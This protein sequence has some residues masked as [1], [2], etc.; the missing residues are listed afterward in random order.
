MATNENV[1]GVRAD[2]IMQ[3]FDRHV[4]GY[5]TR[6]AEANKRTEDFY[7]ESEKQAKQHSAQVGQSLLDAQRSFVEFAAKVTAIVGLVAGAYKVLKDAANFR[8]MIIAGNNL[9]TS[10]GI[11]FQQLLDDFEEVTRGALTMDEKVSLANKALAAGGATFVSQIGPLY[12]IARAAAV[13]TGRDTA[14]VFQVIIQG[15]AKAQP[16]MITQADIYLKLK[17]VVEDYAKANG[18]TADSID[19][20]TQRQLV[21][22]AVLE[23]GSDLV[24]RVGD[25]AIAAKA[26]FKQFEVSIT[27]T[28]DALGLA[29]GEILKVGGVLQTFADGFEALDQIIAVAAGGVVGGITLVTTFWSKLQ[30][31]KKDIIGLPQVTPKELGDFI[32]E[33]QRAAN[34]AFGKRSSACLRWSG[35]M[36]LT[37]RQAQW[38]PLLQ[39]RASVRRQSKRSLP[40][41]SRVTIPRLKTCKSRQASPSLTPKKISMISRPKRGQIT[42]RKRMTSSPRELAARAKIQRDYNDKIASAEHDYQRGIEDANYSHGQKLASIE[43]DY[44]D[45]I[46]GIQQTYQEDALDAVRNLDAIGLLRAKERR[47]KDLANAAQNRDRAMS[48]EQENYARALYELTRALADKRDEADRDRQRDLDEQRQNERDKLDAAKQAYNDQ[49][50]EAKNAFDQRIATI[51]AQYNQEDVEAQAH[52]LH[53]EDLLRAHLQAMQALMAAYGIGGG[54]VTSPVRKPRGG[55]NRADGGVDIVNTPTQF[56]A[57]EAGPEMAMFIPLNRALP[58]PATQVVNHTGDFSHSID[59]AINSSVAGLDGRIMAAVRRAIGEV[60]R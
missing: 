16:R 5:Y 18:V 26:G 2:F 25:D 36:P 10:Y 51:R 21:L 19:L 39:Q 41:N 34:E 3:D 59:A 43:R 52:Y 60:V 17:D 15:I 31:I 7:K 24:R 38:Q 35:P 40:S 28:K 27:E 54:D 30:G 1:I 6:L 46:R 47:D 29:A 13:A 45:T 53:Q 57:G 9:A 37:L 55:G 22:N 50:T 48:D 49:Q 33:A 42:S 14:E 58:M 56:T 44:Q 23:Q 12:K 8:A 11:N 32:A 20:E 4:K